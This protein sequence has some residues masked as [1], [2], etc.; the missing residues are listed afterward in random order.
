[1]LGFLVH[2]PMVPLDRSPA[3]PQDRADLLEAIRAS[4]VRVEVHPD[5]G[6]L[7]VP[8]SQKAEVQIAHGSRIRRNK[9]LGLELLD[10]TTFGGTQF[11]EHIQ[12]LR[13]L[14]GEIERMLNR[15][16]VVAGSR[17]LLSIQRS[18]LFREDKVEPHASVLLEL[19][20]G[21]E[22]TVAEGERIARQVAGAVVGLLPEHVQILDAQMR[23]LHKPIDGDEG[24]N[25]GLAELQ[26]DWERYYK[27]K[28]ESLLSEMLGYGNASVAVS[29]D[30]DHSQRSVMERDINPDKVVTIASKAM[31][32]TTESAASAQGVAGTGS[33]LGGPGNANRGAVSN[34]S[35]ESLNID[36]P[37]TRRTDVTAPGA[38]KAISAAVAIAWKPSGASEASAGAAG[39][40]GSTEAQA[41]YVEWSDEEL[42]YLTTLVRGALGPLATDVSVVN[43]RFPRLDLTGA[44]ESAWS[45]IDRD[46]AS[47][48]A[49]ALLGVCAFLF[50]YGMVLRPLVQ[51]ISPAD[52]AEDE[53]PIDAA[54]V[55]N[56]PELPPPP[57]FSRP[58]FDVQAWLDRFSTG[59]Q[60]VSRS[61]VSRLVLADVAHS[62]VTLQ[63]WLA[64]SVDA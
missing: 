26:R 44:K 36:V 10:T 60:F 13:G 15:Y 47:S 20:P 4:G 23:S 17:V 39:E 50:L 14:Q 34:R 57:E 6:E 18:T 46:M 9:P 33:N 59:D 48:A 63:E 45:R 8:A 16:R 25:S 31:E 42:A 12:Y 38:L 21:A 62:V 30:I 64:E 19:K 32:Q 61:D 49:R 11:R 7:L 41:G 51:N 1:M 54:T 22:L 53:E 52:P 58:E 40:T 43:H 24:G 37:E 27:R 5:T 3:D 2:T 35:S 29:V 56:A 28:I 55:D